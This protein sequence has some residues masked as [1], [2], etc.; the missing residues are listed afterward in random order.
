M[1]ALSVPAIASFR[2]HLSGLLEAM[3]SGDAIDARLMLVVRIKYTA[4]TG[5]LWNTGR[6]SFAMSLGARPASL[7]ERMSGRIP[8]PRLSILTGGK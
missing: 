3:L 5:I 4:R 7:C 1:N 2:H 6:R 8:S